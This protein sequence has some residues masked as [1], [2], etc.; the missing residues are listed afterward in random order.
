MGF[1]QYSFSQQDSLNHKRLNTVIIAETVIYSGTMLGL[2]TLWY[3]D[4]PSSSFHFFDDNKEWNQMD[5]VGHAMTSYYVGKA[6][7]EVMKWSGV[8][9][10]K[11]IWYGGT[12]GLF[13]LT[14]V[15]LFDGF[16]SEWGFSWGDVGVNAAGSGLFIAQQVGWNEQ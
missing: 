1:I 10:K 2:Y 12:L 11:A 7:Y 9:N 6:G 8:N 5:K 16:S 3:K 15:E 13:L 14:S 4:V